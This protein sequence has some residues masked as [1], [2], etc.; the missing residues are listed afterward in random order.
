MSN[1]VRQE[2]MKSVQRFC[3][4]DDT[5]FNCFMADNPEGMQYVLSIIM[6]KKDLIV[7]RIETQHAV[8]NLYA[9]GVRFDVFAQDADGRE[10][11]IEIQNAS[12]GADPRR[13]RYNSGMMDYRSLAA[14][15][16][17]TILPE[18]Y[19]IFITAK[20]VL[21][22]DRPIY[23]IE[24]KIIES[25][26]VFNDGAHIVYVNGAYNDDTTELGQLIQDFKSR[27]A[28]DMKSSVLAARMR[29]LKETEEGVSRMCEIMEEYGKKREFEGKIQ[30]VREMI[31]AGLT[32][33][34]AVKE[35]GL[36]TDKEIAAI[37]AQQ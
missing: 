30:T 28:D 17:V 3:L 4:M 2:L 5:F 37:S 35:S 25:D 27:R 10:Y 36:Y 1:D 19:V 23:H 32:T 22:Y 12:D 15:T 8:P 34:S 21:A 16:D 24:R 7:T 18:T 14:G 31:K 13:A 29:L 20:D 9:R 6:D 26:A 11:N 33:L